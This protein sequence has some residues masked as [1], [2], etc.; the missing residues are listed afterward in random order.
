MGN[1][2]PGGNR[3]G[4]N[5]GGKRFGD[6]GGRPDF[7]RKSFGAPRGAFELHKA[8]CNKCGK[9]C[10][11]PFRPTQGKPVFCKDCFNGPKGG[12]GGDRFPRRD[13]APRAPERVSFEGNKG[14][15]DVK[16]QL[17][18][19]NAKLDKLISVI[20]EISSMAVIEGEDGEIV[21]EVVVSKPEAKKEEKKEE[22]K[23]DKKADKKPAKKAT[24]KAK[25]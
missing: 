8:T 19:V 7:A 1:F 2:R 18:L 3:F 22:K 16:K 24:K 10:E 6:R 5:G 17:E 25:K 15:D 4:G 20:E 13:F 12:E 9:E 23:A 21:E 11:V 14:N